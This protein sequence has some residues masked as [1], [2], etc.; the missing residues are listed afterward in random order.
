[1]RKFLYLTTPACV[2]CRTFGPVV[3]RLNSE[4]ENMEFEKINAEK[5]ID[6]ASKYGIQS[7]P[8]VVEIDD[9]GKELR[10]MTGAFNFDETKEAL[11]I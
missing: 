2:P 5:E 11:S 8:T 7:V 1:M 9:S 4:N 3:K 10:R 6:L